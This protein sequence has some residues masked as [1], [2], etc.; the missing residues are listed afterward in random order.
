[1]GSDSALRGFKCRTIPLNLQE[2]CYFIGFANTD[3]KKTHCYLNRLINGAEKELLEAHLTD[4]NA[5]R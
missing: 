5:A 1:M 4:E 3:L 2:G